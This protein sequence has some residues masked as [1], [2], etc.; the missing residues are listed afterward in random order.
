MDDADLQRSLGRVE[1]K[2]DSLIDLHKESE[3]RQSGQFAALDT[4][5]GRMERWQSRALGW[6]AGVG[7][8]AA[9]IY[10]IISLVK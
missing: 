2:L 9:V 1:G 7:G 10:S 3:E 4:R 8:T 6:S 5:V